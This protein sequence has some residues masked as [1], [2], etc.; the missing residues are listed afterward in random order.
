MSKTVGIQQ[1]PSDLVP[2]AKKFCSYTAGLTPVSRRSIKKEL[3]SLNQQPVAGLMQTMRAAL[4]FGFDPMQGSSCT[5][6]GLN[7][8]THG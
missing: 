5:L 3:A 2:I 6:A 8:N 7:T 1:L 4:D